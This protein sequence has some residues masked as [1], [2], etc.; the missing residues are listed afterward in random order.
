MADPLPETPTRQQS[1]NTAT[2]GQLAA[3]RDYVKAL[4]QKKEYRNPFYTWANGLDDISRNVMA[5][6]ASRQADEMERQGGQQSGRAALGLDDSGSAASPAATGAVSGLFGGIGQGINSAGTSIAAGLNNVFTG[7][8][9]R[10]DESSP[11]G[12]EPASIRTNNPG[13]QQYG[14]TAERFGATGKE[15]LAG[16]Q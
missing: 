14:S 1:T 5:G 3:L 11:S 4:Q 2:P 7:G 12:R 8:Q 15:S 13:A 9:D 10:A 16:R 6:Y